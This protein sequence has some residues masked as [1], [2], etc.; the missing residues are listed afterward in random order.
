MPVLLIWGDRDSFVP[1][2]DQHALQAGFPDA[3]LEVY[4]EVGHAVH[5]EDPARVAAD[6]L[7]FLGLA[8]TATA[9]ES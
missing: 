9:R 8:A 1:R 3:R 5:W 7:T 6:V 4:A 2:R